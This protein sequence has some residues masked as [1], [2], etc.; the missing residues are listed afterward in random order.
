MSTPRGNDDTFN[1]FA[2]GSAKT[3]YN[4]RFAKDW[5]LQPNLLVAY[6]Y[7]GQENWHTDFGE[8]GMMSGM[9]HGINLAPGVNLIWEKETFS[10][11]GTLQYMYNLN[12]SVGGRAGHV[13]LP[14]VHM[15]RGYIQ[16]G[17][18]FNKRFGDRFNG[19]LQAV[20]RNVGRTG[21]GLQAGF[22]WQLGKGG[23]GEINGKT[24]ELKKSE[25]ILNNHKVQ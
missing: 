13:D 17:L 2:G 16:Y 22:Q 15:K 3:A 14:N 5:A 4:W 20:I 18:G 21:I 12:Q 11:Y 19:F 6:N 25:I 10:I 8:M 9:L 24:P 1:Y 23:S 7:F